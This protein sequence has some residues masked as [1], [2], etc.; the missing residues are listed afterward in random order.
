MHALE[1][2]GFFLY[3]GHNIKATHVLCVELHCIVFFLLRT[4]EWRACGLSK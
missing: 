2:K 4:C 3:C 1:F